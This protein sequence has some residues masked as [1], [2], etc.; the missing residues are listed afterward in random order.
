M[1][2]G[3]EASKSAS[4]SPWKGPR[5][6]TGSG[7]STPTSSSGPTTWARSTASRV[8]ISLP[9]STSSSSG[10]SSPRTASR[11]RGT[12]RQRSSTARR[13][14]WTCGSCSPTRACAGCTPAPGRSRTDGRTE[15]ITGL[16]SD[17]TERRQREEAH[18]FLDAAS[19][20]LAASMD[21]LETLEEVARLAV[22][23]LADWCAVQLAPD[24]RG[25]FQQVAVAHVDPAKVRWARELQDRYPPDP[26]A[27]TGA[28]ERDPHRPLRAVPGDRRRP[29]RGRRARRGA[30]PARTRPADALGDGGPAHRARPDA[31]R[32]HV[33]LG[34]VRAPVLH[35]RARAG[36]GGRPP[37]RASPSTTPA[38]SPASTRPPRPCSGR[39]CPPRCPT[40][41]ATSSPSATSPATRTTAPAATG[42]TRSGCPTGASG[43]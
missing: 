22:P 28:P 1:L 15:R 3:C 38:C 18:A 8:A 7:S 36:G 11:W 24:E 42:T 6:A 33:R 37:R 30:D 10:S 17:V 21:P 14:R 27:P 9:A 31:R 40:C 4:G 25:R 19:Q 13:T 20:V 12:S 41:R 29:A 35:A 2:P 26:D 39:C 43:S 23:A 5:P 16:L 32:D 34:G